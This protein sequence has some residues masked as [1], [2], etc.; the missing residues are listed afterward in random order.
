[1]KKVDCTKCTVSGICGV[2]CVIQP[3]CP[4]GCRSFREKE[5]NNEEES[6]VGVHTDMGTGVLGGCICPPL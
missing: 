6:N 1:M 3:C 4:N 5:S 2:Y